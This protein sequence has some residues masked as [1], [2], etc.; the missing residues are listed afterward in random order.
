MRIS[1][2]TISLILS[3]IGVGGVAATSFLSVKCSKKAET[4]ET[5]KEKLIAYAPAIACGVVTSGCI[6]GSHHISAK[7]IAAL[8][9]GCGYLAA[10]REKFEKK[11]QEKFGKEELLNLKKEVAKNDDLPVKVIDTKNGKKIRGDSMHQTVEETGHGD[12]LFV[13]LYLGRKFRSSLQHVEW[14]QKQINNDFHEGKYVSLND[15]YGYLGIEKTYAGEEFGWPAN[16]DFYDYISLDE[17]IHFENIKGEDDNGE[18]MYVI[19]IGYGSYPMV[20]WNE[21]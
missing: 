16:D 20:G 10:N 19:D 3:L 11:I 4:K 9:A 17:P 15:F 18:L 13:E 7:E 2:R 5:K 12:T 1:R 21:V 8:T 6:V 14:A